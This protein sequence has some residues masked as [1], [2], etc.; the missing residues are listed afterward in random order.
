MKNKS[1]ELNITLLAKCIEGVRPAGQG[2]VSG[3]QFLWG[4]GLPKVNGGVCVYIYIYI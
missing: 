2:T 1:L 3:R 4:I